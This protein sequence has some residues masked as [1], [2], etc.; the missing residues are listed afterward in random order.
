VRRA[1]RPDAPALCPTLVGALTSRTTAETAAPQISKRLSE[2]LLSSE[3]PERVANPVDNVM[4]WGY[5]ISWGAALGVFT[6]STA[7][8]RARLGPMLGTVVVLADHVVLPPADL[9]QPVSTYDAET[10]AKD[11]AS[12]LVHGTASGL[13]LGAL[14]GTRSAEQRGAV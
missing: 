9:N 14:S 7:Q 13:A 11:W 12:H 10:L 5:E 2:A 3:L 1:G 6:G 8:L 4:H